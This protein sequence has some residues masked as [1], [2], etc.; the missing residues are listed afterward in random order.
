FIVITAVICRG[1]LSE[2]RVALDVIVGVGRTGVAL[3]VIVGVGRTGV[4]LDVVVG[5]RPLVAFRVVVR[6][7]GLGRGL[8][9]VDRPSRRAL[10]GFV[11]VHLDV[12]R[13]VV[14]AVC[15]LGVTLDVVFVTGGGILVA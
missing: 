4:T 12:T 1:P 13:G 10:I 11:V 2:L 3:D 15:E 5:A 6:V 8:G 7:L 14:V 9:A